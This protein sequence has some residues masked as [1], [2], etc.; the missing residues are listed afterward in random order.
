MGERCCGVPHYVAHTVSGRRH[1]WCRPAHDIRTFAFTMQIDIFAF[2]LLLN[3]RN[4][5]L[6]LES[7]D[8]WTT[9]SVSIPNTFYCYR[10]AQWP[11]QQACCCLVVV[12]SNE[13]CLHPVYHVS[14]L[15]VGWTE[16]NDFSSSQKNNTTKVYLK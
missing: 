4:I 12:F 8:G 6:N 1:S 14:Y 7:F 2:T 3:E 13:G 16:F 11:L 10:R 5:S 9:C 15:C